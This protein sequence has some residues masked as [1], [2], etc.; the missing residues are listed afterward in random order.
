VI[1]IEYHFAAT[2]ELL[3]EIEYLE[4]QAPGL[5]RRLFLEVERAEEMLMRHPE[6]GALAA[7]GIRKWVLL[8]FRYSL[9]YTVNGTMLLIL[10]IAHTSRQPGYWAGRRTFGKN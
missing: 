5:G 8:R 2:E 10:A 4:Q 6:A 7:P 9:I 3:D 1:S